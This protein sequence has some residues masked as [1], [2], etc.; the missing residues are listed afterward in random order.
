MRTVALIITPASFDTPAR[1][2]RIASVVSPRSGVDAESTIHRGAVARRPGTRSSLLTTTRVR[3]AVSS[4]E[5]LPAP[6]RAQLHYGGARDRAHLAVAHSVPTS[7]FRPVVWDNPCRTCW[8][9][10]V[11][12]AFIRCSRIASV[13][14]RYELFP[15]RSSHAGPSHTATRLSRGSDPP[16]SFAVR[17]PTRIA[18]VLR[19]QRNGGAQ[20]PVY[21]GPGASSKPPSTSSDMIS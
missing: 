3:V 10:R 21:A 4:L 9:S 7:P 16:P 13:S 1:L 2:A 11:L 17:E 12:S 19:D 15:Q 6:A 14:R 18:R 5:S 20:A 8:P